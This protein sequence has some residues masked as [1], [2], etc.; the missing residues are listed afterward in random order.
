MKKGGTREQTTSHN[1][2]PALLLEKGNYVLP[3]NKG[4]L[5]SANPALREKKANLLFS[6]KLLQYCSIF[7]SSNKIAQRQFFLALEFQHPFDHIIRYS[8]VNAFSKGS[9]VLRDLSEC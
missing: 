9:Q 4:R 8:I 2:V 3:F 7:H 1:S 5:Q 6:I